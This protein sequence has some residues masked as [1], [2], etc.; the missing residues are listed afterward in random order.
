MRASPGGARWL[1]GKLPERRLAVFLDRDGTICEEMG[2]LN[3]ITRLVLFPFAARAIRKLNDAGIP[4]VV[5]TNQSG[6]SRKIFP[7][8]LVHE[9][10]DKLEDLLRAGGARVDGIYFCP[11]Q[12]ADNC[13][14]RKPL[15]GLLE[16]AA[17]WCGQK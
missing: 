14:C 3:H 6:I 12:R 15:T 1:E 2:Y 5:V 11:H 17:R 7:E 8:S 9:I 13:E 10:H 16:T 4:V